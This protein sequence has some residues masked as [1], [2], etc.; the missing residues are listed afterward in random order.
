MKTLFSA[1]SVAALLS[2]LV[3]GQASVDQAQLAQAL[4]NGTDEERVAAAAA[5]LAIAP[6]AREPWVRIALTQELD[7]Y[8]RDLEVRRLALVSGQPLPPARDEGEYLFQL[9]SA[10]SQDEDP[11]VLSSL[12]PFIGTGNRVINAVAAFGELAVQDVVAIAATDTKDPGPAL[13]TLQRMLEGPVR[14]PL[15][16]DSRQRIV[17]AVAARLKGHQPGGAVMFA[18]DLAVATMDASLLLR[19]Q[20]LATS[21]TELQSLGVPEDRTA[22]MQNRAKAAL[23]A[24]GLR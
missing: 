9:L 22:M 2:V 16:S 24:K 11:I 3:L 17:T 15:S 10:L 1:T 4:T 18:V 12:I 20:E 7:R 14:N 23:E 6:E 5:I 8:R 21:A 19:V 13:L